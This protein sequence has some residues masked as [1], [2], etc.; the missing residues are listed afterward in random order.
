[1]GMDVRARSSWVGSVF[2][3]L[4]PGYTKTYTSTFLLLPKW[5]ADA[6]GTGQWVWFM[7]GKRW[8]AFSQAAEPPANSLLFCSKKQGERKAAELCKQTFFF[9]KFLAVS[10][11][12]FS[13]SPLYFFCSPTLL[14]NH[15]LDAS[16]N[17]HWL[18]SALCPLLA[19]HR[20]LLQTRACVSNLASVF[21]SVCGR[22]RWVLAGACE[23]GSVVRG[24]PKGLIC[25]TNNWQRGCRISESWF[26]SCCVLPHLAASLLDIL[27]LNTKHCAPQELHTE[28]RGNGGGRKAAGKGQNKDISSEPFTWDHVSSH[29]LHYS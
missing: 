25:S 10:F 5:R 19:A 15:R 20:L 9:L 29:T 17:W 21:C 14:W 11:F 27:F 1:M 3:P 28:H 4:T 18:T 16:K 22:R 13:L 7:F 6:K 23:A 2:L 26:G 12:F 8:L 24:V